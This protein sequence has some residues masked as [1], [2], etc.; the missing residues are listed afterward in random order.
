[1]QN[2]DVPRKILKHNNMYG[3]PRELFYS[4]VRMHRPVHI[5]V[6]K[7]F[8]HLSLILFLVAMT[9]S[10]TSKFAT[11]ASSEIS[12]VMHVIFIV[13]VGALPRVLEVFLMNAS[14]SV[15]REIEIR[16]IEESIKEYWLLK[17]DGEFVIIEP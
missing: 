16:N 14:E 9:L 15:R 3:I 5:Q 17:A 7:I 13:T 8:F 1:M 6:L 4:L 10:I 2:N 11:G 12:D